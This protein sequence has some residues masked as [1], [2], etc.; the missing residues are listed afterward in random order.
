MLFY[1]NI[2]K[3]M[4]SGKKCCPEGSWPALT[5]NYKPKGEKFN[6]ADITVYHVGDSQKVLIIIS[7]IFGASSARHESV[8]DTY[9]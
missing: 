6:L 4:D 5:V 2:L 8:A 1:I 3:N 7:D 9:A